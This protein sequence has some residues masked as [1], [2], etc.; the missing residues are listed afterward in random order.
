MNPAISS[1][2]ISTALTPSLVGQELP[3]VMTISL[4]P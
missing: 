3:G 1:L 4:S 2:M